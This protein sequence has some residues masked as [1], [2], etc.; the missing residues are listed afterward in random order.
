MT[1]ISYFSAPSPH[2]PLQSLKHTLNKQCLL[3]SWSLHTQW[4]FVCSCPQ[5]YT[6][7][8][9]SNFPPIPKDNTVH[10]W[11][12]DRDVYIPVCSHK[13]SIYSIYLSTATLFP[14]SQYKTQVL[15]FQQ[16]IRPDKALKWN[17]QHMQSEQSQFSRTTSDTGSNLRS[18][19]WRHAS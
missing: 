7:F 19:F 13:P 2:S 18:V 17:S 11:N 14:L 1:H 9:V 15:S 3:I 4:F 5:L 12:T 10:T 16:E 8:S 6:H